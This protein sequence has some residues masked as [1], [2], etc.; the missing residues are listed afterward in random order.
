MSWNPRLWGS[1]SELNSL[2]R[3]FK[4]Q[5]LKKQTTKSSEAEKQILQ[6]LSDFA[7][8]GSAEAIGEL[9]KN[10][11]YPQFLTKD[12]LSYATEILEK[13][14]QKD[15]AYKKVHL[16]LSLKKIQG[17]ELKNSNRR[18]VK[19]AI[20]ALIIESSESGEAGKVGNEEIRKQAELMYWSYFPSTNPN[21]TPTEFIAVG[22][23]LEKDFQFTQA[24]EAYQNFL[25]L[26]DLPITLRL[27]LW[28]EIIR[29]TRKVQSKE[30]QIQEQQKMI[31][32]IAQN[33]GTIENWDKRYFESILKLGNFY[34]NTGD[35][36]KAITTF[37]IIL[38]AEKVP[39]RYK[40]ES[41]FNLAQINKEENPEVAQNYFLQMKNF[42]SAAAEFAFPGFQLAGEF[43]YQNINYKEALDFFIRAENFGSSLSRERTLFWQGLT[44]QRLNDNDKSKEIF[45]RLGKSDEMG[46]YGQLARAM[47][48][49]E[50]SQSSVKKV[51]L[52]EMEGLELL[53]ALN[54][55]NS[56]LDFLYEKHG[57][58]LLSDQELIV[59]LQNL[60]FYPE[61]IAHYFSLDE[62]VRVKL[63]RENPELA[64]PTPHLSFIQN[65]IQVS[66]V[67]VALI[68]AI[69]RQESLFDTNALS[70]ADA[71]GL[72]Q[73][74]PATGKHMAQKKKIKFTQSDLFEPEKN[75]RLGIEYL[76]F[77]HKMFEGDFIKMVAA[78]NAGPSN[79]KKWIRNSGE[80][81][82]PPFAEIEFAESIPFNE[83][84]DYVIKV[85][86]NYANYCRLYQFSDC[87]KTLREIYR[88]ENF[89]LK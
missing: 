54:F 63:A 52:K 1:P 77:L 27:D 3:K 7:C 57:L 61:S 9:L 83:T 13:K 10:S 78:Y 89:S 19:A 65:E 8:A 28:K 29:L 75:L 51:E 24:L 81:Y 11:S 30:I 14:F 43:F 5:K 31:D 71:M 48:K 50:S 32:W 59:L 25:K 88:L 34:W 47:I 62:S 53:K 80:K 4:C 17:I 20:E 60:E 41:L 49:A 12:I 33:P 86:R 35:K 44:H 55:K 56:L 68:F 79:V 16:L 38:R 23:D 87:T 74:L 6:A 69:M 26:T 21:P 70:P 58:G 22:K 73:L 66:K 15:D 45:E 18:E 85:M 46:L 84:R 42:Q 39:D 64:Y 76:N 82:K 37:E 2:V 67:P 40:L 36:P 72:L